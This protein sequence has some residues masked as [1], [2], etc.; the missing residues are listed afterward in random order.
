MKKIVTLSILASSLLFASGYRLPES[1]VKSTA[2]SAA[3]VANASGADA[4][5]YNPANMA[6]GINRNQIEGALTYINLAEIKYT[7][8]RNPAFNSKS[9]EENLLAPSLFFAS[10]D[11]DGF[12]Y[13]ISLNVPGGLSK[14]WKSPYAKAF[15]EEFTLKIIEINPTVAYKVNDMFAVGGGVRLIYSEGIVKSDATAI[16]KPVIRDMEADTIEY[17]YNL[18]LTYKPVSQLNIAATYRSNVDLNHEGNAELY[19]SGTK[20]YDGGASVDVPLPA[21]AAL[22][23]SYD[24]GGTVVEAEW[25]RTFW[26]EYKTLDFQ[27]KDSVP[28]ALKAPFDDP[29]PRE[30]EDT[31]AFR[32]GITHQLNDKVTLMGAI[33]TDENPAPEK[34]LGFELPDSDAM[35]Y[36]A[37]VLYKYTPQMTFGASIL[38]DSK[39]ER[40]VKNDI[41]DGTF[42]DASATLVTLGVSYAY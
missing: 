6:F 28:A 7:D 32:L 15:A 17:G 12:R 9:E 39:D 14:R 37:G 35:L 10:K 23:I 18:A 11:Y 16:G 33:A 5:Y 25:D 3:Y 34:N 24:F 13:G 31:D 42:K 41:I 22:A 20:L 19:L 4:T 21:V 2:L 27:F 1:S 8:N 26:S 36:S 29:K 40:D 30:W 38:Y